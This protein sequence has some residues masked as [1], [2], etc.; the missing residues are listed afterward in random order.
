[1]VR[2]YL[3]LAPPDLTFSL[4]RFKRSG[5]YHVKPLFVI[6]CGGCSIVS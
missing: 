6:R 3:F 1:M 5:N 4:R 2:S